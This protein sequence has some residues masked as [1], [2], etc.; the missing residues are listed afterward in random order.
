MIER[1]KQYIQRKNET[2]KL[3]RRQLEMEV[4]RHGKELEILHPYVGWTVNNVVDNM[5]KSRMGEGRKFVCNDNIGP[6]VSDLASQNLLYRSV[7]GTSFQLAPDGYER[8]DS[9]DK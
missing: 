8:I 1:I 3:K 2:E 5:N 4:L 6:L 7:I 9:I